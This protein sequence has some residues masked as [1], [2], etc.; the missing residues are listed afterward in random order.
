[1]EPYIQRFKKL[2][3]SILK[4]LVPLN[5][6]NPSDE[7]ILRL[8]IAAESEAINLYQQLLNLTNDPKIQ[9]VLLDVITEEKVH[10]GEFETLLSEVDAEYIDTKIQGQEEVNG[11]I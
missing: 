6:E 1:M 3:E 4:A 11:E 8:S 5:T 2:D 7:Q 10:I 9:E